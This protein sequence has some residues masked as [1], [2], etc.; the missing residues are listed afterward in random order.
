[1]IDKGSLTLRGGA[2]VLLFTLF[3]L[4]AAC[5]LA[6]LRAVVPVALAAGVV[7]AAAVAGRGPGL[8]R[9]I[10]GGVVVMILSASVCALLDDHSF[11]GNIYHQEIIMALMDGWC[12]Y[13]GLDAP[14]GMSIWALHYCKAMEM[15]AAAVVAFT[16]LIETGKCVNFMLVC[17]AGMLVADLLRRVTSWSGRRRWTVVAVVAGNPV[18]V[19]QM[20]TYYV[21]FTKYYYILVLLAGAVWLY[22]GER[23]LPVALMLLAVWMAAGTKFNILFD[24]VLWCAAVTVWF[25]V[26]G[27]RKAAAITASAALAG[28]IGGVLLTGWHP[29]V[30]NYISHGSP[31]Y[32]LLG[33]GAVDIMDANTP[34][35]LSG[36]RVADFFISLFTVSLPTY[37]GRLGGFGALMPV[38]LVVSAIALWRAA[39]SIP[40]AVWWIAALA[41]FSCFVFPQSWWARYNCQLWL[42]VA[43]GALAAGCCGRR[44]R[45]LT[46]GLDL[47]AVIVAVAV[48]VGVSL[49]LTL[50]RNGIYRR[51]VTENAVMYHATPQALRHFAEHG[52][53]VGVAPAGVEAPRADAVAFMS[54][55]DEEGVPVVVFS[56]SVYINDSIR[57]G[58]SK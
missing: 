22:R 19:C 41:L 58:I 34:A 23:R 49:R 14:D 33:E 38:C 32:P 12:P 21:D 29:Y 8:W 52:V 13:C 30:T 5:M 7:S 48:A 28:A 15:A 50:R 37:G 25:A 42:V 56:D 31:F 47:V 54:D 10:A 51:A 26:H 44:L 39:R 53:P 6:P 57:Q 35:R 1:M 55:I 46:L 16:G 11:D 18:G 17:G 20:L 2:F 27:R 4:Y 3:W 40:S 24:M 43:A 36:N 45:R 9:G